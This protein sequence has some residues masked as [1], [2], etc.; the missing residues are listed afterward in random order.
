MAHDA[1]NPHD[2]TSPSQLLQAKRK[3][4]VVHLSAY[5]VM[6]LPVGLYRTGDIGM[7]IFPA[8]AS[9]N[10]VDVLQAEAAFLQAL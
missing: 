9:D 6:D 8:A 5:G 2:L 10:V 4:F 1:I 3:K 7:Y